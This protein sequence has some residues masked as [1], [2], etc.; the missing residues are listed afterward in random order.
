MRGAAFVTRRGLVE[1][2]GLVALASEPLRDDLGVALVAAERDRADLVGPPDVLAERADGAAD[3][4]VGGVDQRACQVVL[5]VAASAP[6]HVAQVDAVDVEHVVAE[7]DEG[8]RDRV[9]QPQVADPGPREVELVVE[10]VGTFGCPGQPEQL[11]GPDARQQRIPRVRAG[12]VCLVE[13]DHVVRARIDDG[14][15]A[16]RVDRGEHVA[17]DRRLLVLVQELAEVAQLQR[18]A[19]DPRRLLEDLAAMRHEQERVDRADAAELAIVQ[20]GHDRLA[21]ARCS[22]KEVAVAAKA[23][24]LAELL[25]HRLL[26][27]LGL[28]LDQ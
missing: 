20:R 19:K 21:G 1:R 24:G 17:A 16:E 5:D 8:V 25:E 23:P 12:V 3:E 22:D 6:A 4:D 11:A 28:D 7:R 10:P 9:P 15:L 2:G 13:D 26:V 14:V 27:R 18:G